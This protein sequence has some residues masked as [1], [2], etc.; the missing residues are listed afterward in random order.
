M[1]DYTTNIE[2]FLVSLGFIRT[3]TPLNHKTRPIVF[4]AVAGAG[5]TTALIKIIQ[6][7]PV[8]VATNSDTL[9]LTSGAQIVKYTPGVRYNIVDEYQLC[10]EIPDADIIIGDPLQI[11]AT[12]TLAHYSLNRTL[13]FGRQTAAFVQAVTGIHIEATFDDILEKGDPFTRDP[14]GQIICGSP[15]ACRLLQWHKVEHLHPAQA[16]GKTFD[17]VTVY[18]SSKDLSDIPLQHRYVILTRHRTLL[19]ILAPGH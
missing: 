14:V 10:P 4:H 11:G 18:A 5:K 15:V 7:Y 8:T 6:D 17:S 9:C 19:L 16:V 2:N 3:P 12:H 1:A 13:R